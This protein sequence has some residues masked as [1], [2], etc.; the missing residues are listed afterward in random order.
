[1][2]PTDQEWHF[3]R[4]TDELGGAAQLAARLYRYP[5]VSET[6]QTAEG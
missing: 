4:P 1:L 5:P 3:T 2:L 6:A